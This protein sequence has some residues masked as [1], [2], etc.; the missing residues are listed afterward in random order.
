MDFEKNFCSSPWF[1]MRIN[2]SG[3]YEYCR[4]QSSVPGNRVNLNVNIRQQ[5][6]ITFFKKNMA[7]IRTALLQGQ[8]PPSCHECLE[9]DQHNKVSGRQRQLLKVGVKLE[10]FTKSLASS[11]YRSSFE[12]SDQ[13]QG[14]TDRQVID[15]QI[16]L[17]N[18][19]N[20]G[21]VF[22]NPEDS[23]KI[24]VEFLKL[25]L[26][27]SMPIGSWC[28][29]DNLLDKFI[30]DLIST[31]DL[32]YIH[33]LGGE[34]LITPGF[35]KILQALVNAGI[36][37]QVSVGFTTNLSL[38]DQ[39]VVDLLSQC[40]QVNLGMSIETLTELNDY[41]RWPVKISEAQLMLD[42]WV[43]TAVRHNWLMQLR[44][45]PTCLTVHEIDTVYDYAWQHGIA[46]ES[47]NFIN[48]PKFMRIGVLP[49]EQR[50]QARD[51]LKSWVDKHQTHSD[52]VINTRDPSVARDQ[53]VQ[54]AESYVAY[55]E[56][57]D[58]ESQRLPDLITFLKRLESNRNNSI[59][60][61]L[62]NYDSIFRTAGY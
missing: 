16:D 52:R 13:H 14:N 19:C 41:V 35:K 31:P 44:I 8:S 10:N 32:R 59:L 55:L 27:D 51:R 57:A 53:I 11:T 18:F 12:Y 39:S 17:G 43:E 36:A 46:V 6:P 47:C 26:I 20:G 23:S 38:W 7:P 29:D 40:Q 61:Y 58:D 21:C 33:F 25:G 56:S 60:D 50:Q 34:T 2:N 37:Q 9:V 24:A 1:H 30:Q 28:D 54:D 42:R 62:P 5:S 49:K 48:E 3:T 4:W 22:C 15:W 45:T